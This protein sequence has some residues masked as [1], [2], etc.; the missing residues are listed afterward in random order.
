MTKG[1]MNP[2]N[3][4]QLIRCD[5]CG[6]EVTGIPSHVGRRHR[7]CRNKGKW[8]INKGGIE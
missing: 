2:K 8:I 7:K 5:G 4:P 3:Q 6:K 1:R